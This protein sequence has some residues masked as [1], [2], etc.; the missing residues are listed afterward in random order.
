VVHVPIGAWLAALIFDLLSAAG[1][2]GNAMLRAAT[3]ARECLEC[4]VTVEA[5]VDLLAKR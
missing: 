3:Y 2:G 4:C 5:L 1:V